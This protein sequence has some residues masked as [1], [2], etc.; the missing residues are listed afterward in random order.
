GSLVGETPM[1]RP[2]QPEA[3]LNRFG[4]ARWAIVGVLGLAAVGCGESRVE[5]S[6]EVT[7]DGKPVPAGRIYFNPD[8]TKGN[9]GPQGYAD[10]KDGKFDTRN[11]GKGACGGP[12]IAV[13]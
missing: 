12:T 5:V 1:T 13:I 2:R 10:I 8:F 11:K 3:L 4:L 7:F 6:G 9:D